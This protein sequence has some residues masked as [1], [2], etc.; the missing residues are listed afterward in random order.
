MRNGGYILLLLLLIGVVV[1]FAIFYAGGMTGMPEADPQGRMYP[2]KEAE[3][4]IDNTKTFSPTPEQV[5]ISKGI[6]YEGDVFEDNQQ[7]GTMLLL[8]NSQGHIEG[9]WTGTYNENRQVDYDIMGGSFEGNI[10]PSK[11]YSDEKGQDASR[12]YFITKG[13]FMLLITDNKSGQVRNTGGKIYVNGWIAKNSSAIGNLTITSGGKD[14]KVFKWT[15]ARP[16][17][18]EK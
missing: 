18:D 16:L 8:I 3:T 12:L 14:F 9:K 7:R 13:N 1:G 10:V 17:K 5:N 11:I 2:W 4:L 6:H 15:L